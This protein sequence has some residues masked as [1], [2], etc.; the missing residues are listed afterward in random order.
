MPSGKTVVAGIGNVLLKDEGIGVHVVRE[1]GRMNLPDSV[2][3]VDVGTSTID[4]L[5]YIEDAEKLIIVD[6]LE[7]G[8]EPGTIYRF[9]P[10]ELILKE[11][12]RGSAHQLGPMDTLRMAKKLGRQPSTVIIGVEPE[13]I[14]WGMDLSPHLGRRM[15]QIVKAVMREL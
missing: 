8:E 9:T 4:L 14:N 2:Q 1:M 6:A 3:L 12:T 11:E 7:G 13:A 10:D 15:T 5:S